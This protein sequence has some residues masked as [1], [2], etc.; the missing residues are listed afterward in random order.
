MALI[1]KV[2]LFTLFVILYSGWLYLAGIHFNKSFSE[3]FIDQWRWV[4]SAEISVI[5]MI[6]GFLMFI[7]LLT[8]YFS[9]PLTV[10]LLASTQIGI[11]IDL[12]L[13]GFVS[14]DITVYHA[15]STW[16][17][18]ELGINH[19]RMFNF[20]RGISLVV[21]L[22][23]PFIAGYLFFTNPLPSPQLTL[24][25]FRYSLVGIAFGSLPVALFVSLNALVSE[26][27]DEE[28]RG[29]SLIEQMSMYV[30]N[31]LFIVLAFWAFGI[32]GIGIEYNLG[33]VSITL[34][35]RL[36]VF[37]MIL[38]GLTVLLPYAMGANRAKKQRITLI[39]KRRQWLCRLLEI[40]EFP[41]G[42][43]DTGKL[44]NLIES[45]EQEIQKFIARHKVLQ[46][47]FQFD[48]GSD[49][50]PDLGQEIVSA[51]RISRNLDPR[52]IYMDWL[53]EFEEKVSAMTGYIQNH[54][55]DGEVE[56]TA[57]VWVKALHSRKQ[58]FVEEMESVNQEKPGVLA[59]VG[60]LF[61]PL[62]GLVLNNLAELI[63][64]AFTSSL[65]K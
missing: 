45:C 33:D 65:I 64:S 38:L 52:F 42:P 3:G 56:K 1:I 10:V 4:W 12:I 51:Y 23:Y 15:R 11:L 46:V 55:M 22:G 61:T 34:S 14:S 50:Q 9:F 57:E 17:G 2:G 37:L 8:G 19:P 20:F 7:F 28:A 62:L 30:L 25:I 44:A 29:G 36:V 59:V 6:A 43:L 41:I 31:L 35:L 58:E 53:R 26:N 39:R 60:I 16:Q 24:N 63:W 27:L 5:L 49:G 40:L 32:S 21:R 18:F 13:F 47:A 48:E 54:S